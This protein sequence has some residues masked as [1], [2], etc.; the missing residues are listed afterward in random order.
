MKIYPAKNWWQDLRVLPLS[1]LSLEP[2]ERMFMVALC[3]VVGIVGLWVLFP[4]THNGATMFL[5]LACACWLFRFPGLL[6]GL[7]LNGLAFQLLYLFQ[8][9]GMLPNSAF[10]E[11][12]AVGFGTTLGLGLIVCWLRAV[13]LATQQKLVTERVHLLTRWQ[14]QQAML[15]AEQQRQV[16]AMKDQFLIHISHEL[17]TPLTVVAGYLDLLQTIYEQLDSATRAYMLQEARRGSE[18]LQTLIERALSATTLS[19][20]PSVATC[21]AFPLYPLL[22]ELLNEQAD[23]SLSEYTVRLQGNEQVMVWAD[24][25]L[26]RWVLEHLLDNICKYVPRQ[27]TITV[28]VTQPD[29]SS[30]VSLHVQDEGPGIPARERP[31]LFEKCMRLSRDRAGPIPGMGLGLYLCKQW[32]QAMGGQI[33]V[34]STGRSGEGSRFCLSLLTPF[35]L[36]LPARGE[37]A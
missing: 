36:H 14:E 27:T 19:E 10:L 4:F 17:L 22:Q 24:P 12:G 6:I 11:G 20:Q 37:K 29:P 7:L 26:V 8:W 34:E 2:G 33:W 23:G 31:L 28:Q 3:Y 13:T 35:Q 30:P 18:Q 15:A 5:P 1:W 32:V 25:A 21:S 9:Q 16:A